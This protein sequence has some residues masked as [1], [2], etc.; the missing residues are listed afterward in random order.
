MVSASYFHLLGAQ[1][2]RGR[3]FAPTEDRS[4]GR[5]NVAVI[6]AALW[7]TNFG[8]APDIIGRAITLNDL[9]FTVIGV[10]PDD[11][12]GV[13]FDT[14]V[15]V[16][17]SMLSLNSPI[18]QLDSRSQRWLAG[19]G[20]LRD[21]VSL[22]AAQREL[23][24]IAA[25]LARE[26]PESN[27]DRGVQLFSLTDNALGNTKPLL[28]ALFGSVLLFLL[29][30]CANV[31]S[32]QLVRA[33]ARQREM[34]LRA[35]LGADRRRLVQQLLVEGLLLAL[36]GGA[37][38]T[39]LAQASIRLV[40]PL[41][42]AGALPRY[43]HPAVDPRALLFTLALTA[44]TGVIFGLAPAARASRLDLRSG[45]GSGSRAASG[46][47]ASLRKLGA[48]QLLVVGEVALAL[49]LL[50]GA[51]LLSR[52]LAHL[53]DVNPGFRAQDALLA[54]LELPDRRYTAADR[55]R[56]A[57]E[58]ERRIA[59]TSGVSA[60]ALGSDAPLDGN[61]GAAFLV[62]DGRPTDETRYYHHRV[63]PGYFAALQIPLASGRVFTADD[64]AGTPL[65]AV[66]SEAFAGRFWPSGSAVGQRIRLGDATGPA[67]EIVGVVRNARYRD[68][69]TPLA[70]EPD[71]FFA[72]A[73]RPTRDL[74]IVVR[75]VLPPASV[76][77]VVRAAVASLDAGLAVFNVAPMD[78][79]LGQQ[80][81]TGRFGSILL[82]IFSTVALVLAAVGVYGLLAFVT[83][84]S[85]R[86]IAIRVA[87]GATGPRVLRLVVGRGM[88]L[89]V[90]G[91]GLG[92][93]ASV[94]AT[95]A[96]ATQLV[97]V[98]ATDPATFAVVSVALFVVALL[99]TYLPA[100]RVLRIDPQLALRSE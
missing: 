33:T 38:G 53:L 4:P 28:L 29:I 99:A 75:S 61:T 77:R 96:I 74:A 23:D 55:I 64:R 67:V 21:G 45:L 58:L 82:G 84:L 37:A 3:T 93:A 71:V 11:V 1:A 13:S 83:G 24:G 9:P 86:E 27:R 31:T 50:L 8:G 98:S 18:S 22:A 19:I 40:L 30:A 10:M 42:P 49:V 62:V 26:R 2:V 100:R 85:Q 39:A 73:Q 32:L 94:F 78:A 79:L 70:R 91:L 16:P 41:L 36:I 59:A 95:E 56:F 81:A 66:V 15:W 7:F 68:L 90:L 54:R 88:V 80:T 63:S 65:V 34:A 17:I 72:Y 97:A 47:L 52:S 51:G 69:T 12:R 48:Q 43:A 5:D 14:D 20:R 87:L 60:V 89:V 57:Q 92:A 44:V 6:S 25:Q 35:A 46:G 76:E